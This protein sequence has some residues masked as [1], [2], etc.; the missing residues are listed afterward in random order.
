MGGKTHNLVTNHPWDNEERDE[1]T[2]NQS[3][4]GTHEM[5]LTTLP[6]TSP[7]ISSEVGNISANDASVAIHA[8]DDILINKKKEVL[9]VKTAHGLD[10]RT[11]SNI[12]GDNPPNSNGL[13]LY[14]IS[15]QSNAQGHTTDAGWSITGNASYWLDLKELFKQDLKQVPWDQELYQLIDSVH[16]DEYETG[17][18]EVIATLRDEVIRL[19]QFGLLNGINEPLSL[20]K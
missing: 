6:K 14:L 4:I 5:T 18:P 17:P 8:K 2:D 1:E 19:Q 13:D 11:L 10:V 20:G 3:M 9:G 15:G 7:M 12:F 16:D